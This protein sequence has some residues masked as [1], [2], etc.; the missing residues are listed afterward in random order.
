M[1]DPIRYAYV[2]GAIVPEADAKVSIRDLGFVYGD[3]VFDTAVERAVSLGPWEPEV[4]LAMAE[5]RLLAGFRLS[6]PSLAHTEAAL[7]RALQNQPREVIPLAVQIGE[8]ELI[9]SL[10]GDDEQALGL[11]E[12]ELEKV[13]LL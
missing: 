5:I 13:G 3:A 8:A 10:I 1:S 7:Q 9:R 2:N 6:D 11:L 4:Q 12:R